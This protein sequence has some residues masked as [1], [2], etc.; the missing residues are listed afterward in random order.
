ML[1]I[2][3]PLYLALVLSALTKMDFY[4]IFLLFIFVAY[5]IFPS[6]FLKNTVFLLLIYTEFFVFAKYIWTL[7]T[8]TI[9]S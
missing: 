1:Y 7:V 5:T 8:N 4:H 3:Y 9:P 2:E 6:F